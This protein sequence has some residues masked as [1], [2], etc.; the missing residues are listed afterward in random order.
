MAERE[1][2]TDRERRVLE[3]VIETYIATAEPAGSQTVARRCAL[4][5]SPASI[6]STMSDLEA[7]GYL[8][9]PHT[10]AG[11]I[12]T[13]QA[14]RVYVDALVQRRPPDSQSR[15]AL[16]VELTGAVMESEELLRRAAQV[17]GILTQE[18][19]VAVAPALD[20]IV[21]ER[22]DLVKVSA[23]RLL[24]VF[25]LQSGTVRT[26]YVRLP[27]AV[28]TSHVEEVQRILNERLGG[29]TLRDIRATVSDRLRD[30]ASS[31]EAAD[32]L[33]IVMAEGDGWFDIQEDETVLLGSAAPLV[34]QPEFSSSAR[35]RSLINITERRDLL[36][37]ALET[38]RRDGLKVT[39]GAEHGDA[40]LAG[41]TLVTSTYR[42]G[43]ATGVIGVLGPT[44]MPYDKIIGLV[45][46][47]GRL[48]EGLLQ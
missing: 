18:L 44:R 26:I 14:Y 17:L 39:I 25:N 4:G 27:L 35:M 6:R 48:V 5:I 40:G 23:E 36:R 3:A 16:E 21:L 32:L 31:A 12:P 15:E 33:D 30:A 8:Y 45:E 43:G 22:L 37:E 42:R 2:L 11:R 41:F 29:L 28:A 19:G 46:H 34:E 1:S 9:H 24:L 10:S 13:D 38:R 7:K 47:T 20:E